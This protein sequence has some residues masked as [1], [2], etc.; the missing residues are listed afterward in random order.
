MSNYDKELAEEK[1]EILKATKLPKWVLSAISQIAYERGHAFGN[2]EIDGIEID[3]I[4][5]FEECMKKSKEN[6]I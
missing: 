3:M 2:S 5:I 1:Q 4:S 6:N